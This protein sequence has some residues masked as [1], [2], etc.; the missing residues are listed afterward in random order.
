MVKRP[1]IVPVLAALLLAVLPVCAVFAQDTAKGDA[2]PKPETSAPTK[3]EVAPITL[4]VPF[5]VGT[6]YRYR[7]TL[8]ISSPRIT[9]QA[10][11]IRRETTTT[12]KA[13]GE[14]LAELVEE[15]GKAVINGMENPLPAGKA[16][17]L[18][19]DRFS[20]LLLYHPTDE[21]NSFLT[22]PIRHI[23]AL[24]DRIAFPRLPVKPGDT[25]TTEVRNPTGKSRKVTIQST[26]LGTE[27]L[28]GATAWKVRQT[29]EAA[30]ED[31][32]LEAEMTAFLDPATGQLL[33]ADQSIK[34]VPSAAGVV[35]WKGKLVRL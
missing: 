11:M 12:V 20:R 14:I 18:L 22:P 26:Y 34:N 1:I 13:N 4:A 29:L 9:I 2:N 24:A 27:M 28:N 8:E 30:T 21:D 33:Q 32:T 16:I 6:V 31:G 25:W 35:T 15:G 17:Q 23:L 5:A 10:E 7:S 19:M 3:P